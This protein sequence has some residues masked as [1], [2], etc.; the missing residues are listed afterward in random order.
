LP[1]LLHATAPSDRPLLTTRRWLAVLQ[2]ILRRTSYLALLDE[3]P[4]ALARLVEVVTR[5]ALLAERLAAHPVLLDELLDQRTGGP[6]PDRTELTAACQHC[7]THDD[8]EAALYALNDLRQQ[9]SFRIALSILDQRL[10]PAAATAHLAALADAVVGA[11]LALARRQLDTTHGAFPTARFLIVGY[12]SLG[13]EEPGFGSDLDLVFLYDAPSGAESTGLRPLD[14][15]RWH[16]RLA[17]KIIALLSS[18]TGAGRLYETDMRLRPDGSKAVLVSTM[19]QYADYQRERAWTF[20]HQAL[21][22]ARPIAGDETLADEFE[23]IRRTILTRSRDAQTVKREVSDMRLKMRRELDRSTAD[24]FDLKQ[25]E[26][27]LV[28]LEFTL[29][30]LVLCNAHTHPELTTPRATTRLIEAMHHARLL[31]ASTTQALQQAH[32]HLL[33]RSLA[34]TLDRRPRQVPYDAPLE[35]ARAAVRA[36]W[37]K[38]HEIDIVGSK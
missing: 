15:H 3:H 20:E 23:T 10:P 26:G 36:A 34:C 30:T 27:G 18:V 37:I 7:L 22:R 5:S 24:T 4:P 19:F 35:D 32:T 2:P 21:V 16:A 29:Q 17:Q 25:G 12:G 31:D 8:D 33:A 38:Q 13:G 1:V 9:V 14:A 28:D 11:V 6:L